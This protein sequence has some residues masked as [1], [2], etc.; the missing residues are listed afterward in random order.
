MFEKLKELARKDELIFHKMGL[1][2][3]ALSGILL[4]MMISAKADEYEVEIIEEAS[5]GETEV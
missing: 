3:G 5:D 4:G 1:G 2:V